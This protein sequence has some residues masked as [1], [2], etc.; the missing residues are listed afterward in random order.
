MPQ[1]IF[2]TGKVIVM[3][4]NT[5]DTSSAQREQ[6]FSLLYALGMPGHLKGTLYIAEA[7]VMISQDM[8]SQPLLTKEVYPE[9]AKKY[10]T[11]AASVERDI[12]NAIQS[13][14]KRKNIGSKKHTNAEF[15]AYLCHNAKEE[16]VLSLME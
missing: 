15:L 12:R 16:H 9:I 3:H 13:L 7:A 1:Q 4:Q 6:T 2:Q 11:S 14:W 5:V 10:G 8:F